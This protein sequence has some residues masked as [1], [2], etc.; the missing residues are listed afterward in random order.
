MCFISFRCCTYFLSISL[1]DMI[2]SYSVP[3]SLS[4]SLSFSLHLFFAFVHKLCPLLIVLFCVFFFILSY[5]IFFSPSSPV[6]S[7][8]YLCLP[9]SSEGNQVALTQHFVTL[10]VSTTLQFFILLTLKLL[11]RVLIVIESIH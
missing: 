6:I 1:L 2:L 4:H 11:A 3:L 9:I 8:I 7:D 10:T 5:S